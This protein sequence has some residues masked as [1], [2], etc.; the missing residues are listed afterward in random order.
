[1]SLTS[2][3]FPPHSHWPWQKFYPRADHGFL[4]CPQ[5]FSAPLLCRLF[6]PPACHF[7][8]RRPRVPTNWCTTYP[9]V[10]PS[11]LPISVHCPLPPPFA[12]VCSLRPLLTLCQFRSRR[13]RLF[14][15]Q[16]RKLGKIADKA[17]IPLPEYVKGLNH[18]SPEWKWL[19][20]YS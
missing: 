12:H 13:P 17:G 15:S 10:H 16:L 8:S 6:D 14:V 1:M 20:N 18:K 2:A 11:R 3:S 9:R 7:R 19:G 4:L 5:L